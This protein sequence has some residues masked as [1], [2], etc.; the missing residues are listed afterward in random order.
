MVDESGQHDGKRGAAVSFGLKLDQTAV[1]FGN[2]RSNGQPEPGAAFLRREERLEQALLGF[3]R[4]ARAIV[5][6]FKDHYR[7]QLFVEFGHAA[8]DSKFDLS[9]AAGTIGRVLNKVDEQ[10][11]NLLFVSAKAERLERI[12]FQFRSSSPER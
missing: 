12:D 6:H 11:L 7:A 5:R 3:R 10:L 9:A 4:D 2:A 8:F 1:V